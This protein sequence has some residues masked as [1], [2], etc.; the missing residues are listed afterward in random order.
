[1]GKVKITGLLS[2]FIVLLVLPTLATKEITGDTSDNSLSLKRK[3]TQVINKT[4]ETK[5]KI[6]KGY[7]KILF[8]LADT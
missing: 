1:M 7:I 6:R 4:R 5:R 3:G 2:A 8:I